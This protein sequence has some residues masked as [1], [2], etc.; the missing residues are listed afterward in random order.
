MINLVGIVGNNWSG[1]TNRQLLQYMRTRYADRFSLTLLEPGSLPL[2]SQDDEN[3][4][5]PAVE[6]F[7]QAVAGAAGVI[8]ATPEHNH[9]IPAVLKNALDWCSRVEHPL[10]GKRVMIVGS[11]LGP[12]GTV[13][14]QGH[15]RQILDSPA[16]AAHVLPGNEF[17]LAG[18]HAQFDAQ[19]Q[20][21]NPQTIAFLDTCVAHYLAFLNAEQE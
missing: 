19:G 11:A 8:I 9:S 13:R 18:A 20:L 3:A 2:F 21:T 16:I 12:M 7:R 4:P 17:L 10:A 1:S 5:G 15:L 6:A 14:A